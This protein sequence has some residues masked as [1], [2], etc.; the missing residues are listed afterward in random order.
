[1][2]ARGRHP[3]H[4]GL[5]LLPRACA[6]GGRLG[7]RHGAGL[8]DPAGR[9]AALRIPARCD[10]GG[11][12][13]H[14]ARSDEQR[15]RLV[16]RERDLA[17][18]SMTDETMTMLLCVNGS[19]ESRHAV[20]QAAR[21]FAGARAVV[22]N[23]WRPFEAIGGGYALAGIATDRQLWD[24]GND[25]ARADA[26][27]VVLEAAVLAQGHGLMPEA[28]PRAMDKSVWETILD[29]AREFGAGLVVTGGRGL[30]G[31]HELVD[32]SLSHRLIQHSD[33][34]VLVIPKPR[35]EK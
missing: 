32:G 3:R 9:A 5:R 13:D 28:A 18:R 14:A 19:D 7:V 1:M 21:L 26:E 31:M 30:H 6:D 20:V 35:H 22:L 24:M 33:T 10:R 17:S 8:A 15:A 27:D 2:D 16:G 23:V 25:E 4:Q 29:A 11:G 12:R 34:P